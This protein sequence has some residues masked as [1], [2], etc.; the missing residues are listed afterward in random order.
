MIS[1]ANWYGDYGDP[2]TFLDLFKSS[3]NNNDRNYRNPAFD[4]MMERADS[5]LEPAR[6]MSLLHDAERYI[7]E[8]ELPLLPLFHRV[9]VYMYEPD[10]VA[11]IS[12]HPRLVQYLWEMKVTRR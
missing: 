10:R 12:E 9:T 7:V 6:R 1:Q 11:H 8:E 4:A 2:T 3:N 5:E